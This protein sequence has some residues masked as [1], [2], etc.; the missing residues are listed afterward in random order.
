MDPVSIAIVVAISAGILTAGQ[1]IA[2]NRK[3]KKEREYDEWRARN[4]HE[5]PGGDMPRR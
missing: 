5:G 2:K 1:K 3:E 4:D